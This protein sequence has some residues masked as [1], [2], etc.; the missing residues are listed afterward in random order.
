MTL[1]DSLQN[2]NMTESK[3]IPIETNQRETC[4]RFDTTDSI[5]FITSDFYFY[6]SFKTSIFF[7]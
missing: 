4:A 1:W 6:F 3:L 5:I 2:K 7:F